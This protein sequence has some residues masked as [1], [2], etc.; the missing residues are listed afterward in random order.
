MT[1]QPQGGPHSEEL[2]QQ[3]A[4]TMMRNYGVPAL[5]LD[6]GQGAWVWD[7]DGNKYLDLVAGI[8]VNSLG[9]AH[10]SIVAAVT[11]QVGK[12]AHT[13]NLAIHRPGLEL[14]QRLAGL[15][16]VPSRV[17]LCQDGATANEAALKLARKFHRG[18]RKQFVSTHGGFHG[19]TFGALSVTGSPAKQA[20]F[21]PLV[22]PVAFVDFGDIDAMR[23][24]VTEATAAVIVEPIQ[25]EGGVIMPPAD[26]L[27]S[28][29]EIC[30]RAGALLIVDEVQSG[31]GRTGTW[32]AS[33]AA[34]VVPDVITLA[35][36]LGGGLP[37]GAVIATGTAGDAFEPG[38]H[39]STFG[40][41]PISCAAALAVIDT[42]EKDHL[43]EHV[44][45]IGKQLS[46]GFDAIDHPLVASHRGV[47][48]WRAIELSAPAAAA[49]ELSARNQGFLVNAV[50]PTTI[51]LAPPLVLTADQAQSFL[52]ALPAILD[53]AQ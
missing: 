16:A 31:I 19:R 26:Y 18:G 32:L 22:E 50:R 17:F 4:T 41:N 13:S 23:A 42:I 44:D 45:T 21:V 2:R 33:I 28:V 48:L 43:L 38:D 27:S 29:R 15:V 51:R 46:D 39:G 25:G 5:S 35:K 24:A 36:G 11:N 12:L 6:H 37:I 30:T 14:A 10:P 20:P 7:V 9:H 49:V 8:A 53:G 3:W 34:G 40:G 52:D 1:S 47:G